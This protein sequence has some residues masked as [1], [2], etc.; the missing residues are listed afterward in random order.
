MQGISLTPHYQFRPLH[1]DL[2]IS[3]V[4]TQESSP[5]YVASSQNWTGN[6]LVF[7]FPAQAAN[8]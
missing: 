2:E 3:R 1:K 4:I 5:L 7:G 6:L 8:H